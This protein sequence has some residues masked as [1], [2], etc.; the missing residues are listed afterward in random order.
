LDTK[1]EIVLTR[2]TEFPPGLEAQVV[3][4][5]RYPCAGYT[6]RTAVSWRLDTLTIHV[7]GFVRPSPCLADMS[8]ATGT[9]YLGDIGEGTYVLGIRYRGHQDLHRLSIEDDAKTIEPIENSFTELEW[10]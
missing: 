3:T 5:E 1:F 4:T 7:G 8:R 9:A 10:E 2:R 6:I